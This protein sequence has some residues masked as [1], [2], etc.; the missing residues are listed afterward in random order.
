MQCAT[1]C[2]AVR[3]LPGHLGRGL[4]RPRAFVRKWR[5]PTPSGVVC[6]DSSERLCRLGNLVL[7]A[8]WPGLLPPALHGFP[9]SAAEPSQHV[10][11]LAYYARAGQT[12]AL[13]VVTHR[14]LTEPNVRPA[15][16]MPA[17][18]AMLEGSRLDVG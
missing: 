1:C 11:G 17:C 14:W 12:S 16:L 7:S 10:V 6:I 3:R 15:R 2:D 5:R 13:V 8:S 4:R 9:K 18:R